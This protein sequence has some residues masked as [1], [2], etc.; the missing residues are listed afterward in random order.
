MRNK[1][2][3][4]SLVLA[5]IMIISVIPISVFGEN[6]SVEYNVKKSGI[7]IMNK[8]M[9]ENDLFRKTY[10]RSTDNNF[11]LIYNFKKTSTNN[12]KGAND[13]LSY[14]TSMMHKKDGDYW[15]A[16]YEWTYQERANIEI[17]GKTYPI[18]KPLKENEVL[19]DL[20]SKGQIKVDFSADLTA[21]NHRNLLRHDKKILDRAYVSLTHKDERGNYSFINMVSSNDAPDESPIKFEVSKEML[22][23]DH[24][25]FEL[26]FTGLGCKCGSSKVSK[27]SLGFIDYINP[28]I[29]SIYASRD[30]DGNQKETNGFK[31]GDTGYLN[32]MFSE[33]IRFANDSIPL[34][35]VF[36]NLV[37]NGALNNVE[38]DTSE[39]AAKL[40]KLSGDKMTFKFVVPSKIAGQDTN[41]Y[42]S[43]IS[44]AQT[45]VNDGGDLNFPLI[46]FGKDG[47]EVNLTDNLK[48]LEEMTHVSSL[49]TDIAGNPINWRNSAKNLSELCFLD[50]VAPVVKS[51]EIQGARISAE[52]NQSSQ[53]EDWPKD[54]DRSAVFA[55]IGDKLIYSVK[56][57]EEMR[58]PEYSD[59]NEVVATLNAKNNS[60][61][62][63]T[64]KA[65]E[66]VSI[67]DGV[68][69]IK[70]SKIIFEVLNIDSDMIPYMILG[71]TGEALKITEIKFP[72]G[73]E[74]LRKNR[75]NN[76]INEQGAIVIP[77]PS[78]Q[79][80]LDTQLP[81]ATTII[82][83]LEGKY[84]PIY[85]VDGDNKKEF[86]FPIT[87]NDI[88]DI[89]TLK[90][91]YASGINGVFG[92]FAWLDETAKESY[93][94]EYYVSASPNKPAANHY[95]EANTSND[96]NSINYVSFQ[97][98]ETGNYIHI[99]LKDN[100]KYNINSSKLVI[101]PK[102][103]AGNKGKNVF[104]LDFSA[105]YIAPE[106]IKAG[107]K[108]SYND[109]INEG[110]IEVLLLVKDLSGVNPSNI[111]YQWVI[112]GGEAVSDGWLSG[113]TET[114]EIRVIDDPNDPNN[115]SLK[116]EIKKK[117][118]QTNESHEYDLL[119]R[120]ED[121]KNNRSEALRVSCVYDLE[122]ANP[123]L[124]IKSEIDKPVNDIVIG[125]ELNP[126]SGNDV[127]MENLPSKSILMIKNPETQDEDNEYFITILSSHLQKKLLPDDI[128][129]FITNDLFD[130]IKDDYR[131]WYSSK[132]MMENDG[133]ISFTESKT[134]KNY[135]SERRII[136]S[137]IDHE[138][139]YSD[140]YYG[141]V[142]LVFVTAYGNV[143]EIFDAY[144]LN[145]PNNL[146]DYLD[147]TG[148]QL[149]EHTPFYLEG[150][151]G[152][153]FAKV[154]GNDQLDIENSFYYKYLS[155]GASGGTTIP[156]D[157]NGKAFEVVDVKMP[158]TRISGN[159]NIQK[160]TLML[161]PEKYKQGHQTI[162][163]E[164]GKV[165]QANGTEGLLWNEDYIL[166]ETAMYLKNLDGAKIQ[167]ILSNLIEQE[168]GVLDMDFESD[169]T[170][171]ALYYTEH[172][173]NPNGGGFLTKNGE[174]LEFSDGGRY[175]NISEL[176]P[177]IKTK[178]IAT[179]KEQNFIIPHGLT[180]KV[181]FYALEVSIK[182]INSSK[183]E[184]KYYV[185]MFADG[186]KS[187]GKNILNFN[188][189]VCNSNNQEILQNYVFINSNDM[190]LGTAS[191]DTYKIDRSMY[192][193]IDYVKP[194]VTTINV[195][196]LAYYGLNEDGS[197]GINFKYPDKSSYG[198]IKIW[199]AGSSEDGKAPNFVQWISS[200]DIY[201]INFKI[202][203]NTEGLKSASNYVDE[204][205]NFI[206]P[207]T[208][209]GNNTICYQ[210][211]R[212]NGYISPVMQLSIATSSSAPEF[213]LKL[214]SDE[215]GG[216]VQ[217]VMANAENIVSL[218]G[219]KEF[220]YRFSE[221]REEAYRRNFCTEV[222]EGSLGHIS[223]ERN[224]EY[225]FY[226][227]DNAGNM[228]IVKRNI[229]WIDSEI[230]IVSVL[231]NNPVADNEFKATITMTDNQDLTKSKLYLSFDKEYSNLLNRK[232]GEITGETGIADELVSV[233]IPLAEGGIGEWTL[234]DAGENHAGIY[235]TNTTLSQDKLTKT[236]EIWGAFKYDDLAMDNTQT[237]RRFV[238]TGSDQ[239]GNLS[240]T[241]EKEYYFDENGD[242][243]EY[244]SDVPI[245]G[246]YL[247]IN[248]INIK[249]ELKTKTINTND[250]VKLEFSAPVLV[251][252]PQNLNPAFIRSTD[253]VAIYND[254]I[255][256][257]T[258]RDLFGTEYNTEANIDLFGRF[259][260][261]IKFSETKA[262]QNDISVIAT[263]QNANNDVEIIK[264]TGIKADN[265]TINGV[266]SEDKKSASIIM[267][268]NGQIKISM[269]ATDG[270]IKE[271]IVNVSN[272]DR[273]IET[274]T[275]Y[276]YY[277]AGKPTD[278]QTDTDGEVIV[279]LRCDELITGTN[280]PLTYAFTNGA[281]IG[282]SYTFEYEDLAKNKGS[283]TFVLDYNV[284]YEAPDTSPPEY[285]VTLYSKLDYINHQR[286]SFTESMSLDEAIK[287][288]P[289]SQGHM[290]L[291]NIF[292]ESRVKLIIKS[293]DTIPNYSDTSDIID[294]VTIGNR[295]I[296]IDKDCEF[297]AYL[298]D[299]KDNRTVLPVMNF[300]GIDTASPIATVEYSAST[301]YST[302][303]YIMPS[304][305]II[306]T[307]IV[308]VKK[309]GAGA[310]DYKDK[311][312]HEF[313]QNENFI[314]YYKDT[315]GNTGSTQAD[316]DWLD[317][318]P[319]MI[320][321]LKWTP[322]KVYQGEGNGIYPP[323]T[324]HTN[325]DIFAQV[326]FNKTVK[327]V[328]AY[329]KG[330]DNEV[331]S[332]KIKISFIQSGAIITY[333]DNADI[334][335]YFKSYNGKSARMS[336]GVITCIDK[337]KPTINHSAALSADK[338]SVEFTFT[339]SK[340]VYMAEDLHSGVKE[341]K[342]DFNYTF[343][344]NGTYDMH[345]TDKAGN[346]VVYKVK[347]SDLDKELI[348]AHYNTQNSD[349]GAVDNAA[350]LNI[351]NK[352]KFYVKL[353]K[354]GKINYN[355]ITKTAN[356][357]EWI[358]FD[359]T[360]IADKVFY[361]IEAV[362]SVV[363]TKIYSYI[364]VEL[365][366]KIPP[367]IILPTPSLSIK[368]GNSAVY[369]QSKLCEGVIV[370][371]NKDTGL[372][373]SI[374]E[375]KTETGK[376]IQITDNIPVGKY[377]IKYE[378]K[379]KSGNTSVVYRVL[380]IY[381]KN[382][383]NALV[384]GQATEPSG[385][386]VLSTKEIT[387][388]IENLLSTNGLTEPCKVYYKAGIMT[389]G[390]MKIGAT[391]V[392]TDKFTLPATGFY[393]IYIQAQDRK[394]YITYVYIE[395]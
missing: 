225:Y 183:V 142:N 195:D 262:T 131:T 352:N 286:A 43:G 103:Y 331:E 92:S 386:M 355:S 87:I 231:V 393:T 224:G 21:D 67:T 162:G 212:S 201:D 5:I 273:E 344:S 61:E 57:S 375:V 36:L 339:S 174:A 296:M 363:G 138:N 89:D 351:E 223:I 49:V 23:Y 265:S 144:M 165:S 166:G 287:V 192:L 316:V 85:Y 330:T 119:V 243:K 113:P 53:V 158:I 387:L 86:Y 245:D 141:D 94:F 187:I 132:V 146:P 281:K 392:E 343:T 280:G 45:W 118:L 39:V 60:G 240:L 289:K 35:P 93:P 341:F 266:V 76:L 193:D 298:V 214:D 300:N 336:L 31:A 277:A 323:P 125:M 268:D 213:E 226:V 269:K 294:G 9:A 383:I 320:L 37:I 233:Q 216:F 84:S 278:G 361:T 10:L 104:N 155:D 357:D 168:W 264:L 270:E 244:T 140:A 229:D 276:V 237:S 63:V 282:D 126:Y 215:T 59:I 384:N 283:Y 66:L 97:Q 292:D 95:T 32:L 48:K 227:M 156:P 179:A 164:F 295:S 208:R 271:R 279:G 184:K 309:A 160:R 13:E 143:P 291:F 308:G 29:K 4:I 149:G 234:K 12:V 246:T 173:V 91:S 249:P 77:A 302:I 260:A 133:S 395:K 88:D 68:N 106:I 315:V 236:V 365:P 65:K 182:P 370:S 239:A 198:G 318:S 301:F 288:L 52:S 202:V 130:D 24:L 252:I 324:E 46:I 217:S 327:E 1:D 30:K 382:S 69:G 197:R 188:V 204:G 248:S 321:S 186:S 362:D 272:I 17:G 359:F 177:L 145:L 161:A 367:S 254:G 368:E 81:I 135:D 44:K 175:R 211:T 256:N 209:E 347:V 285:S 98:V 379:D 90:K 293:D 267:T 338:Q 38:I 169:D 306:I 376:V 307:N 221:F 112:K 206:L 129:S 247:D 189:Y 377:Q 345:F 314:F 222:D 72:S 218:N 153:Y 391:I 380:R 58:L 157:I 253:S 334:D 251:T 389:V 70:V 167:F 388:S 372:I 22:Q 180:E 329:Y 340:A 394:D 235:K 34:E 319:P 374:V 171:V 2:R 322:S 78:Q 274:V 147:L 170:Y 342:T 199:N 139:L 71:G 19:M 203:D 373:A 332:S 378:A 263:L 8:A 337:V 108:N 311:Y 333:I 25:S 3:L 16:Y 120:A 354:D 390:Q 80:Y 348:K 371:D 261:V 181:G 134:I 123:N 154:D 127:N 366:D 42:I 325:T 47:N 349:I 358:E 200:G 74:D 172:G 317:T 350:K 259:N 190:L 75:M 304:E 122:K 83:D 360:P 51:V 178:P 255:Y 241:H 238:F 115:T 205:G 64:L 310:G 196:S 385:T 353:S 7:G 18:N 150:V 151:D 364:S 242:L 117:G 111:E 346:G 230:P 124:E 55:G 54:I 232:S 290:L 194:V 250:K 50:N 335:L 114:S 305:D 258:F 100:I 191:Q 159:I 33:N 40:V 15:R 312:Y 220:G 163:I 381:D 328:K 105:D 79:Q 128:D 228:S 303:G 26:Y 284:V 28:T 219:A 299:E 73:T 20:V 6:D 116:V 109:T 356:K 257:I 121:I 62:S 313:E 136:K 207:I 14:K 297:R 27:P 101:M 56:F 96:E 210:L 137:I 185:D 107:E 99:R 369:I 275:P 11:N 326:G 152:I 148:G 82:S 102:D 110:T 176:T 41:V